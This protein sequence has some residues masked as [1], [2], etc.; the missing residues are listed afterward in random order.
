MNINTV[1]KTLSEEANKPID[2]STEYLHGKTSAQKEAYAHAW[3]LVKNL[4]SK[5]CICDGSPF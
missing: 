3:T 4:K 2:K 1:L 5:N